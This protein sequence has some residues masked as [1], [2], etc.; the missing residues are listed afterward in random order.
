MRVHALSEEVLAGAREAAGRD[1]YHELVAESAGAPLRC[2]LRKARE[3]EPLVLFRYTPG[4]GRGPYEELGPV[5]IHAEPCDGQAGGFP[6]ELGRSP[7]V[8]RAY[9]AGGRIHGGVVAQPGALEQGVEDLLA[10]P[11]VVE[12]QVRSLSHGCFLFAVTDG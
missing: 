5:F 9:T 3:G 4:A 10:E 2:C 11:E 6:A 7:R 1:E 8:L 12:V